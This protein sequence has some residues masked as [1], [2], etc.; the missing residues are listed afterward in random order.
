MPRLPRDQPHP[1]DRLTLLLVEP[2]K[3]GL[4]RVLGVELEGVE[5]EGEQA[6]FRVDLAVCG[7]E[8]EGVRGGGGVGD[9]GGEPGDLRCAGYGVGVV[10]E[11]VGVD[12]VAQFGGEGE[13]GGCWGGWR[14]GRVGGLGGGVGCLGIGHGR[15][16]IEDCEVCNDRI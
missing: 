9:R 13:E 10:A 12:F 4:K 5:R 11:G 6:R 2:G 1:R 16:M 8:G 15:W 3:P 7:E 14:R